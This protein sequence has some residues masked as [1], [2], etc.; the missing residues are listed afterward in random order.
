MNPK[1]EVSCAIERT[2]RVIQ[3]EGMFDV[4]PIGTQIKTWM[5][6][7][8]LH[9]RPWNVGL[10]VGPSG[11]GKSTVARHVFADHMLPPFDWHRSQAVI[12]GFP[13]GMSIKDV[14]MLLS[15]VGFSSPPAWLRPFHALSNGEQFRV[16][17]AR[18]LAESPEIAVMDEFTSVVDRTVAQ[19][20]SAAVEKTVRRLWK[21]F[22]AVTCH[23]DVE[24]WLNP[25]WVYRPDSNEFEW[26]RL[27]RRPTIAIEV[28]RVHRAA[29]QLFKG[30]HY[31]SAELHKGAAC[32][33][34]TLNRQPAVFVAVLSFPH[35]KRPGWKEHRTV[36]RPDFQGVGISSAVTEY[37]AS[38]Y[39]ATGK[40]F[41]SATSHPALRMHRMRSAAWR[42]IRKP[43]FTRTSQSSTIAGM[44]ASHAT[45][46]LTS[47][48]E[49]IGPANVEEAVKFGVV[50]G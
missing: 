38:L 21:Q 1:I 36:V 47:S 37:I 45:H 28:Q 6:D 4:P 23:D 11:S 46:R 50:R 26:R 10:I 25:D 14:T 33:L 24:P 3:L 13:V 9:E 32:F 49:F 5:P 7:L 27:H 48:F 19:I 42:M 35:A 8:P 15:S 17:L 18:V 41:F 39:R 12:D 30:Y 40:P 22:V 31:L 2:P 44:N 16:T 34:G 29:W 43:S 20:G